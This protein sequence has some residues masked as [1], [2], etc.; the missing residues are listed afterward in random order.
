MPW[1]FRFHV[2]LTLGV[3]S[4]LCGVPQP[5]PTDDC[6]E[7]SG[8]DWDEVTLPVG[9]SVPAQYVLTTHGRSP[10]IRVVIDARHC[11]DQAP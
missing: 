7:V 1:I 8:V 10:R 2:V 4:L 6:I 11:F 3:V 5:A 9:A